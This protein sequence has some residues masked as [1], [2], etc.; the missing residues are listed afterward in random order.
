MDQDDNPKISVEEILDLPD[1]I[2][3]SGSTESVSASND[4]FVNSPDIPPVAT[5]QEIAQKRSK[6]LYLK[7]SSIQDEST[8]SK[9]KSILRRYHGETPVYVFFAAEKRM[10]LS[11]YQYW[12]NSEDID[13]LV[14]VSQLIG[15]DGI[16][17]KENTQK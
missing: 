8:L 17:I 16:S 4:V 1:D 9:L 2:S 11:E 10:I 13:F 14:S 3:L 7:L 12:A 5:L 15:A 6:K